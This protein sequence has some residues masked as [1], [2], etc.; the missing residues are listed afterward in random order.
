MSALGDFFKEVADA[1]RSKTGK[2]DTIVPINFPAEILAI[3]TGGSGGELKKSGTINCAYPSNTY[4]IVFQSLES[5]GTISYNGFPM[6]AINGNTTCGCNNVVIGT[7]I[8]FVCVSQ[9]KLKYRNVV[10]SDGLEVIRNGQDFVVVRVNT[11]GTGTITI[12]NR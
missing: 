4:Q 9:S 5:D 3:E 2:T 10:V 8:Y 7:D 11:E 1:I 6:Y 12:T